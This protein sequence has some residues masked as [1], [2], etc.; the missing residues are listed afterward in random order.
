MQIHA[1]GKEAGISA[2]QQLSAASG[3]SASTANQVQKMLLKAPTLMQHQLSD[4]S[5][6]NVVLVGLKG[7]GKSHTANLMYGSNIFDVSD[8]MMSATPEVRH[9]DAPRSSWRFPPA[10]YRII[11]T[12]SFF[13][14]TID[15]ERVACALKD[16]A[17]AAREGLAAIVLVVRSGHFSVENQAALMFLELIFGKEAMN[18][19]GILV[20][21][22][23]EKDSET[24]ASE[25]RRLP[26]NNLG[27]QVAETVRGRIVALG[28]KS[29][30]AR[31]YEMIEEIFQSSQY[32]ALDSEMMQSRRAKEQEHT[33]YQKLTEAFEEAD[34][35]EKHKIYGHIQRLQR[36]MAE[37]DQQLDA[38]AHKFANHCADEAYGSAAA[39]LGLAFGV[40]GAVGAASAAGCTVM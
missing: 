7:A 31:L 4:Q 36:R 24:L 17:Q 22:H 25:F 15:N 11:D 33:E 37:M 5:R 39:A 3:P 38:Q 18:K 12:P 23:T 35:E 28:P 30:P 13:D 16:I 10:D 40:G 8:S 29:S 6:R 14:A 1:K 21:T 32:K 20:V 26:E 27:R 2:S 9:T 19:Y 34:A